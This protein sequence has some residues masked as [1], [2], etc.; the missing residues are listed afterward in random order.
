MKSFT[1]NIHSYDNILGVD[2]ANNV[3]IVPFGFPTQYRYFKCKVLNFNYNFYTLTDVWRTT[4]LF[5]IVS[6]NF[7]VGDKPKTGNRSNDIL[8]HMTGLG[9]LN[10]NLG[11][12]FIIENPNGKTINFELVDH[13]FTN[14]AGNINVTENTVWIL[15]LLITP[16][17]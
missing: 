12:E 15:Q 13:T 11:N 3:K 17:E 6:D 10:N 7:M 16:I 4:K 1:F 8:A 14:L 9:G 2:S 5:Y